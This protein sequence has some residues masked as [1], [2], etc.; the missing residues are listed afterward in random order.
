MVERAGPIL[1]VDDEDDIRNLLLIQL[2]REGF[3]AIAASNG[4][5]ALEMARRVAP[6]LVILDLMLPGLS[7]T[8]VCRRL[9]AEPATRDVP[10]IM[11]SAR[12]GEIDRVVGFEVGADDYV[13]KPFS[14][15]ELLLRVRAVLR[16]A[17]APD[18]VGDAIFTGP[19]SLLQIDE[20]GHRVYV[21]GEEIPLTPIE[22]K[23]LLSL[24]RRA[25]RV[26]TRGQLLKEV[27]SMPADLNTRTVD[28]HMK[29]LR[30]KLLG[31]SAH[32][33]TVRGVGYRFRREP[34]P[35]GSA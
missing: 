32:I 7:G 10:I 26:R 16:R 29:R 33:E 11:L 35:A 3:S 4:P 13:T 9:R 30:E 20:P 15:R 5:D 27:W 17:P 1:V 24:V 6:S 14:A 28:T 25:D 8:E 31:A 12:S 22:F 18:D 2:Q 34:E 21:L 23:L 19:D